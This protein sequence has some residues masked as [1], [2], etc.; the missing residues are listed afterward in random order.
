MQTDQEVVG[1][2]LAGGFQSSLSQ[3]HHVCIAMVCPMLR[4]HLFLILSTEIHQYPCSYHIPSATQTSTNTHTHQPFC[5][6]HHK[7][8]QTHRHKLSQLHTQT[9]AVTHSCRMIS[10]T[11]T[12][13]SFLPE[14]STPHSDTDPVPGSA[15]LAGLLWYCPHCGLWPPCRDTTQLLT[16]KHVEV[17]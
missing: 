11:H 5:T 12:L 17:G 14:A 16:H 10:N 7:Q 9:T 13:T 1:P 15:S 6:R 4:P 8:L 3:L 2:H